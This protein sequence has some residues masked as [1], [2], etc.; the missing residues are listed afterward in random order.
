MREEDAEGER[1][2]ESPGM[3]GVMG[4]LA[5]GAMPEVRPRIRSQR[6]AGD[7]TLTRGEEAGSLHHS[8]PSPRRASLT[9]CFRGRSITRNV[10]SGGNMASGR[11]ILAHSA[12]GNGH[13]QI[14]KL[15]C[16][17]HVLDGIPGTAH[18]DWLA[19]GDSGFDGPSGRKTKPP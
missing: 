19:S 16:Y 2:P 5:G 14:L 1:R 10:A 17:R 18:R 15:V 9:A 13:G 6:R 4:P 3:V 11:A 12:R 8:P 7:A